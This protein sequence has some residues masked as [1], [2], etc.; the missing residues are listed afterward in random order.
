MKLFAGVGLM[1][2]V[3]F[4]TPCGAVPSLDDILAAMKYADEQ[5]GVVKVE[6]YIHEYRWDD[7]SASRTVTPETSTFTRTYENKPQ[8]P[9]VLDEHP[10]VMRWKDGSAPYLAEWRTQFRDSDGFIT[11]WTR[12]NQ[13]RTTLLSSVTQWWDHP[14]KPHDDIPSPPRS[15][16]VNNVRRGKVSSFLQSMAE[17]VET[18]YSGLGFTTLKAARR[19]PICF[20]D[21]YPGIVVSDTPEGMTQIQYVSPD[22]C[23]AWDFILDPKKNFALV[24]YTYSRNRGLTTTDNEMTMTYEV[25]EH[26]QIADG[27][28]YP[29]RYTTKTEF[30]AEYAAEMLSR[31]PPPHADE[32]DPYTSQGEEV[33]LTNVIMLS[34]AEAEANLTV[35]LPDGL[36]V[37]DED[38]R[39]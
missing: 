14:L 38:A 20:P 19:T 16:T 34:G 17:R 6:G 11:W 3:A 7:T 29:V 13:Y 5:I 2:S 35:K 1:L 30:S 23:V 9:Y 31:Y 27:V 33:V 22:V 8:G 12:T 15:F 18:M 24:R 37:I 10:T 4:V 28:W 36:D 21:Q 32:L 25:R 39:Q 26:R